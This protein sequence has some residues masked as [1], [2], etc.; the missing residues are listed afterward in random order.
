MQI[1]SCVS[2]VGLCSERATSA[3]SHTHRH[4]HHIEWRGVWGQLTVLGFYCE[5]AVA[6]AL[7]YLR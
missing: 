4:N 5:Y 2:S 1:R 3:V 7:S 6:D